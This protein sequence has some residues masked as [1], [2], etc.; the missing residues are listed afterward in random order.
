MSDDQSASTSP[1]E[2]RR[3]ILGAASV[4]VAAL[5]GPAFAKASEMPRAAV[6]RGDPEPPLQVGNVRQYGAV[7][8]GVADDTAAIQAAIDAFPNGAGRVYLPHGNYRVSDTITIS[9]NRM[10]FVGDGAYASQITFAPTRDATC[11]KVSNGSGMVVQGSVRDIAFFSDDRTHD[12]TAILLSD[13]S[14]YLIENVVV[15]GSVVVSGSQYWGGGTSVALRLRGREFGMLRNLQ[16]AADRPMVIEPNPNSSISIDHFHFEDCYLTANAHPCV[17]IEGGVN[18]TNVKF[19]GAQAWVFG[20][21]GLYWSDRTSRAASI[22]LSLS[23]VRWEQGQDS[24]AFLVYIDHNHAL[25]GFVLRDCYGGLERNGFFLRR[26]SNVNLESVWYVGHGVALDVDG[27]VTR[28]SVRDCFWQTLS[29]SKLEAHHMVFT[30]PEKPSGGA[31]P[32][33]AVYDLV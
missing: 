13:T 1:L 5:A 25:A 4:G 8:D 24:G 18:L 30:V 27:S 21:H 33:T 28:I 22:L 16:F 11:L 10:H 31:L 26:C 7:G 3:F 9:K 19:N 15:G 2:R 23:G 14:S 12:K 32:S 6:T 20:T 17:Q 29:T